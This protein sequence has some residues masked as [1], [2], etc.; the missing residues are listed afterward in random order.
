MARNRNFLLGYGERLTEPIGSIPRNPDPKKLPYTLSQAR[1]RLLPQLQKVARDVLALP[2]I[3]CPRDEAV[4]L[5]TLH[6]EFLAKS[7]YPGSLFA[8]HNLRAVGSKPAQVR[9][10]AWAKQREPE[11]SPTTE[12]YVAGKRS[13]FSEWATELAESST[14]SEELVRLELLR[15]PTPEERIR[16]IPEDHEQVLLEV[17]LHAGESVS[18]EFIV[19]GFAKFLEQLGLRGNFERRL[20]AGGLCF[21]PVAARREQVRDIAEYSF[22]RVA[23]ELPQLRPVDPSPIARVSEPSFRVQLPAGPPVDPELRVAVFDGGLDDARLE[24]WASSIDGDGVGASERNFLDHGHGVTS[25]LL[26]GPLDPRHAVSRPFAYVDH[27]RVLDDKVGHDPEELYDVLA[28]IQQ[29]LS[30][31]TYEFIS[32][33][34]GPDLP[35]EDNEVH[36]WTAVLDDYLADGRTLATVAVG[37]NG[38]MDRASGNARVQ[39]PSDCVNGLAVGSSAVTGARW[40][41]APYSALGPGRSPGIV[42]PDLLAFGGSATQPFHVLGPVEMTLPKCGTSFATPSVMRMALGVRAHLGNRI[43]PLALKALLIHGADAQEFER[44]EVGWGRIPESLEEIVTCE[45]GTA[46][47]L[48]QGELTPAKYLRARIPIPHEGLLGL[49]TI[50]A[51]FCFASAVDPQDPGNYTRAG[52]DVWFRPHSEVFAND[53]ALNP[54]TSPFFRAGDYVE[55]RELRADAHKWETVLS[56]SRRMQANSLREP[57]FD[58]H[59]NARVSG[60]P[61]S[62]ADSPT[63]RCST[64]G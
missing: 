53:G 35:I 11:I 37:N 8:S 20:Y 13:C 15:A 50:K 9:P 36:S 46:R 45:S 33:S 34:I 47:V 27:Y 5:V 57:V 61:N 1:D 38:D 18:S 42:K 19:A 39:V 6:P 48:Y 30:T 52:L 40:Y 41:K 54:K 59:Y 4:A 43:G 14:I 29:A 25:A 58:V 10:S 60:R 56:K 55:E 12:I 23:R 16:S 32:L 49:V 26:F 62:A 22:L 63:T 64:A 24:P 7:Y 2:D 3:A 21:L 31:R 44:A 28:R 17:A 51:T